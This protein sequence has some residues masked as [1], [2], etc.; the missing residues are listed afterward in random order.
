MIEDARTP[1]TMHGRCIGEST[2]RGNWLIGVT[3]DLAR[4]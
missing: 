1:Y 3:K 4:A 2:V